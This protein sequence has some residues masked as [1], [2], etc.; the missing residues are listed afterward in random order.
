MIKKVIKLSASWCF[1]CKMYAK[2]FEEVSQNEEFKDI[3]FE[4]I[5]I[6]ENEDVTEKYLVRSVPTTVVLDEND[7]VIHKASGILTKN[8]LEEILRGNFN[9]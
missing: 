7:R 9:G 4:E 8:N 6:E 3:T 5:D 1:P 2:T